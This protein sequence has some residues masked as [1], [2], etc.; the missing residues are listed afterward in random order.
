[1]VTT[2]S[3]GASA[4]LLGRGGVLDLCSL[5][6]DACNNLIGI[7][8]KAKPA[9]A[10]ELVDL[11]EEEQDPDPACGRFRGSIKSWW[12]EKGYGFLE[13]EHTF[14]MYGCDIYINRLAIGLFQKHDEVF[15][16]VE[17]NKEGKPQGKNLLPISAEAK[18]RQLL[19]ATDPDFDLDTYLAQHKL[20]PYNPS[21]EEQEAQNRRNKR[22]GTERVQQDHGR[23]Q[24]GKD[25]WGDPYAWWGP[26][27]R[28][29]PYGG[30]GGSWH[31]QKGGL[32]YGERAKGGGMSTAALREHLF[33]GRDNGVSKGSKGGRTPGFSPFDLEDVLPPPPR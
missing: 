32:P 13:C 30:K 2:S 8:L 4:S 31:G 11:C 15:F 27:W 19:A 5:S 18:K 23:G 25:G 16:S 26:A 28:D 10:V 24:Y 12:P 3:A 1:M 9:M 7:F 21:H 29:G 20:G 33:R 17:L 22:T 14:S 6:D